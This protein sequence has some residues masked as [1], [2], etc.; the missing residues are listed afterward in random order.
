MDL[1]DKIKKEIPI[2][3]TKIRTNKATGLQY[4]YDTGKRPLTGDVKYKRLFKFYGG[5]CGICSNWPQIKI[6]TQCGDENQKITLVEFY[7]DPCYQAHNARIAAQ[8]ER[9]INR[10]SEISQLH[11][12]GF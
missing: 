7:C 2:P 3:V 6:L 9:R 8:L 11:S 4:E 12:T 1:I 5:I 10:K